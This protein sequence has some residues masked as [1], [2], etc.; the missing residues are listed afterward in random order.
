MEIVQQARRSYSGRLKEIRVVSID[1]QTYP[2][3]CRDKDHPFMAM[4]DEQRIK[5]VVSIC[6][7]VLVQQVLSMESP[8]K[9]ALPVAA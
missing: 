7:S 6:A 2:Q 9:P 3:F 5:E 1:P 4:P 8:V